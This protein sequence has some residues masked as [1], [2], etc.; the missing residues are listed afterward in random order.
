M[1]KNVYLVL[2]TIL[3][4]HLCFGMDNVR[5]LLKLLFIILWDYCK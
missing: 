2:C 3:L 4:V 1:D 5:I